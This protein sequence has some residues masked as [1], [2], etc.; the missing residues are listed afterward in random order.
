MNK[1]L[2]GLKKDKI[3]Y[4]NLQKNKRTMYLK[5]KTLIDTVYDI[6]KVI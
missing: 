2:H 6:I 4:R 1:I 3:L 5:V